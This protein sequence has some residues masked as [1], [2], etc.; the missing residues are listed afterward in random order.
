MTSARGIGNGVARLAVAKMFVVLLTVPTLAVAQPA[1]SALAAR[2]NAAPSQTPIIPQRLAPWEVSLGYQS[3]SVTEAAGER[4][5]IGLDGSEDFFV[6]V[7]CHL[8][9]CWVGEM[10][11]SAVS[12]TD[13]RP[14]S[15]GSTWHSVGHSDNVNYG[16]PEAAG[17]SRRV[18]GHG[19]HAQFGYRLQAPS[20][21]K[22]TRAALTLDASAGYRGFAG[23]SRTSGYEGM[24]TH[25]V[26]EPVHLGG[27]LYLQPKV[28]VIL[29]IRMGYFGFQAAYEQY[30]ASDVKNGWIA[31]V[32]VGL[33]DPE[34]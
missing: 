17:K 31:G 10:G 23:M 22:R 2:S 1:K 15:G 4:A 24:Y 13:T 6:N 29:P 33:G 28:Q 5:G 7:L 30:L 9:P 8:A 3:L 12:F 34:R 32:V 18:K 16:Y 11:W 25:A 14:I 20:P 19:L 26:S 27:G 21:K